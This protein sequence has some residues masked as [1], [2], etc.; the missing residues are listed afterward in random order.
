M[1]WEGRCMQM[2]TNPMKDNYMDWIPLKEG[3]TMLELSD[4][5]EN[6][7][8]TWDYIVAG[9]VF[10]RVPALFSGKDPYGAFFEEIKKHLKKDGHLILAVDNRYGLRYFAGC[11]ERLTGRY[12]ESLEGYG[13]SE[14][15][16][17]FSKER[18]RKISKDAGFS[19]CRIYY[20]YPDYCYMTALYTDGHL[21]SP[22]ELTRNLCNL[23][24]ERMVLFDEAKVF[25][26][27]IKEGKFQEFSNSYLFD[28][29]L[30]DQH[31]EE[32][33]LF[34]KY[35]VE[36]D[37]K[38]QIRTEIIKKADGSKIVRK[39]PHSE[40]AAAH[41]EKLKYWE[42][43]LSKAYAPAGVQ[44]NRCTLTRGGAEFE[45]LTGQTL[46]SVLNEKLEQDDFSGFMEEIQ[47]Y[48][49]KLEG[50]LPLKPFV[51]GERF[52]EIFGSV[53]FETPQKAAK[54]NNIDLI[55]SNIILI[56]GKW[57]IIDYEWTFD[58]PIPVKFIIHR[59]V[60][61]FCE[62]K[63]QKN[64]QCSQICRMIGI[65]ESEE[66]RFLE[67]E[68]RLQKYLLQ[69]TKTME[70]LWIEHS[71]KTILVEKLLERAHQPEMKIYEDYG[72]GFSEE[73]SYL[74]EAEE[75]FYGRR[76]I[77]V[78]VPS[79]VQAVRL[80]PCEEPCM[81]TLNRALGECS[82]S[83]ELEVTHNGKSY[84]KSIL[85][86]T[87]DPQLLITGIV[88]GTSQ[89]HLDLTVEYLKEETAYGWS[90]LLERAQKC[91]RIEAS[92]AYRLMKKIKNLVK[93]G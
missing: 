73:R 27:L 46:E 76:R 78:P 47:N 84:E 20:P 72:Q 59:A 22:G 35:S 18:I 39:L 54:L 75:D 66:T 74:L 26:G 90:K 5:M 34:L 13:K 31:P 30:E 51:P 6:L 43:A 79:G 8:G 40:K 48:V 87:T 85:Y 67:M 23:E 42:T 3:E 44:V 50:L 14:G 11:K 15:V 69:D 17:T 9:D 77:T 63:K 53:V 70:A 61:L 12:F 28:L 37:A 41:V 71:G 52:E 24:E 80:D 93:K 88:P 19:G 7:D 60:S 49:K 55:F 2:V 38:Y 29:T 62:Q 25:D 91:D 10:A 64:L 81:V 92:F 21:P 33:L 36:R 32:E 45:F 83:Y 4:G 65:S 82:G 56:D 86:T 57:N 16:R 68:H 58:F 1:T 89:L